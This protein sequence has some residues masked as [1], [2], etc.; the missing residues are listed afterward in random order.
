M[1]SPFVVLL[2]NLLFHTKCTFVVKPCT[3]VFCVIPVA[4]RDLACCAPSH[5]LKNHLGEFSKF[6]VFSLSK[7]AFVIRIAKASTSMNVVLSAACESRLFFFSGFCLTL[8][9]ESSFALVG[10]A[11]CQKQSFCHS[12]HT[13]ICWP[14]IDVFDITSLRTTNLFAFFRDCNYP[15]RIRM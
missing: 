2:S 4:S 3:V 9:E 12:F 5:F 15:F 6:Q 10:C 13:T 11:Q 14:N 7:N 8:R 1:P